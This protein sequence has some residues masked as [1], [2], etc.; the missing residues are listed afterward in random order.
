MGIADPD[1]A[2]WSGDSSAE[3]TVLRFDAD[4]AS[5]ESSGVDDPPVVVDPDSDVS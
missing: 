1:V 2:V 4:L 3:T 5:G